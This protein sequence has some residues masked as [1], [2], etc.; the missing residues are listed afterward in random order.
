M[1]PRLQA[2]KALLDALG[3]GAEISTVADRKRIQKAVYL[4]QRAGANLGY[5]FGWYVRGPYSPPLADAYYALANALT[6]GDEPPADL[7]LNP[8]LAASLK[9]LLPV[10]EVPEGVHLPQED[11]LELLASWDYLLAVSKA[12]PEA[13]KER[14]RREKPLLA[15]MIEEAVAAR[16]RAALE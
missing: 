15:P 6:M 14:L 5:R 12:T 4:G 13:A 16:A 11:W 1:E 7:C 3:V 9:K 2:L 8:G 10:L